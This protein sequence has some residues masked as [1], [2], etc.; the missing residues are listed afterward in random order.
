MQIDLIQFNVLDEVMQVWLPQLLGKHWGEL[1]QLG[2][3]ICRL[4]VITLNFYQQ[5]NFRSFKPPIC[6][7]PQFWGTLPQLGDFEDGQ[8]NV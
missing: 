8:E 3:Q 6:L 7:L 2:N 1:P 4:E 5:H